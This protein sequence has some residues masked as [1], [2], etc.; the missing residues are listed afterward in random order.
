MAPSTSRLLG[1]RATIACAWVDRQQEKPM[2]VQPAVREML[3][4]AVQVYEQERGLQKEIYSQS[5]VHRKRRRST[6]TVF[7]E[8]LEQDKK[9]AAKCAAKVAGKRPVP[10]SAIRRPPIRSVHPAP[11]PLRRSTPPPRHA[12]SRW[13]GPR[14]HR[15]DKMFEPT[16]TAV[17]Q[18]QVDFRERQAQRTGRPPLVYIGDQVQSSTSDFFPEPPPLPPTAPAQVHAPIRP[19]LSHFKAEGSPPYSI[20]RH[21]ARILPHKAADFMWNYSCQLN[22]FILSLADHKQQAL[23]QVHMCWGAHELKDTTCATSETAIYCAWGKLRLKQVELG[24]IKVGEHLWLRLFDHVMVIPWT[25]TSM[26]AFKNASLYA[27][28]YL[29]KK[30]PLPLTRPGYN[31]LKKQD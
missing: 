7:L 19:D 31:C 8:K 4:Q 15:P 20:R 1:P 14:S 28:T 24:D 27:A 23:D 11:A 21:W 6:M 9:R 25:S 22:G 30:G 5:L 13:Q 29:F 10:S 12:I 2:Y 26:P 17:E 16:R 3:H 18:Y